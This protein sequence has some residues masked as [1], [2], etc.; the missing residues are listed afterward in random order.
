VLLSYIFVLLFCLIGIG[1]MQFHILFQIAFAVACFGAT[2]A[3][4][5]S[6]SIYQVFTDRFARTDQSTSAGCDTNARVYCG[7]SWQGLIGKLDYIQNMGFTAVRLLKPPF[8]HLYAHS[9]ISIDMDIPYHAEFA[10]TY[11]QWDGLSWL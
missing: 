5:R 4:W 7:G 3:Q 11:R 2:P 10:T 1:T 9:P 8:R 6:R